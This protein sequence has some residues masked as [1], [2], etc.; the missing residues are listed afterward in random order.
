[1]RLTIMKALTIITIMP[2]VRV[3][4]VDFI[5]VRAETDNLEDLYQKTEDKDLNI[6]NVNVS[7]RITAIRE[8]HHN[9]I[10]HN[11]VAHTNH[12]FKGIK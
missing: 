3:E 6:V 11:M 4:A 1:M 2:Q 9:K 10:V 5:M 8:V 7:F 12:I